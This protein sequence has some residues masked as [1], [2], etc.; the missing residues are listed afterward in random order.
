[1]FNNL[2][3]H[4]SAKAE[5]IIRGRGAWILFLPQYSPDPNPIENA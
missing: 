3:I 1:M 5:A 2:S 4:K